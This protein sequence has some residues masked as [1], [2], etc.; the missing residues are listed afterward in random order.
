MANLILVGRASDARSEVA[1]FLENYVKD[2]RNE[3]TSNTELSQISYYLAYKVLPD[4]VFSRWREFVEL[5]NGGIPFPFYLAIKGAND[6]GKRL[7]ISQIE[8]FKYYQGKLSEF[9][10]YYLIE[11][12]FPPEQI[13]ES[14][15]DDLIA[16]LI[17]GDSSTLNSMPVLGPYFLAIILDNER[18]EINIYIL[19]QSIGGGTTL[20]AI[21]DEGSQIN[22]GSGPEPTPENF[23]QVLIDY[24]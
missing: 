20:R 13:N 21:T 7:S 5:W 16:H 10:D 11:F 1:K 18:H 14:N 19:G 24:V 3:K 6:Q 15:V 23:L 12:P 4:L 22:Y 8:D 9:T 17:Q 2:S